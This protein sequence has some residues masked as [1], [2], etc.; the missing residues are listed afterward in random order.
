MV[1]TRRMSALYMCFN[2]TCIWGGETKC[3]EGIDPG[4]VLYDLS[5]AQCKE[6]VF[7]LYLIVFASSMQ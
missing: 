1:N 3:M 7:I 4:L 5:V 6:Q 2:G